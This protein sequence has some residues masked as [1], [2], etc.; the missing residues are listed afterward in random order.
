MRGHMRE[1]YVSRMAPAKS[2]RRTRRIAAGLIALVSAVW[3]LFADHPVVAS[4]ATPATIPAATTPAATTTA[5]TTTLGAAVVLPPTVAAK[6]LADVLRIAVSG[7]TSASEYNDIFAP[8]FTAHISRAQLLTVFAAALGPTT[9]LDR[10]LLSTPAGIAVVANGAGGRVKIELT[11][12]SASSKIDSLLLSPFSDAPPS[13]EPSSW[14][15]IDT[16]LRNVAPVARFVAARINTNGTCVPAHGLQPDTV[17]PLGSAFKLYV[18][19][20]VADAGSRN[21]LEWNSTIAVREDWKSLPSGDLQDQPAGKRFNVAVLADKMISISDN[22]AADHLL[23]TV[24]RAQVEATMTTAGMAQPSK[25]RPFLTTR[26]LFLLKASQYPKNAKRYLALDEAGRRALLD[27]ALASASLSAAKV[28]STPRDVDTLEWF[29]TP[30][31]I[32]RAFAYLGRIEAR[33]S[34][35]AI[36]HA[37]TINDG[38]LKLDSNSWPTVWFKGGSEPGVLTLAYLAKNVKGERF[39]VVTM[40]SNPSKALNEQDAAMELLAI[41]KGAFTLLTR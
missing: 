36:D 10:I 2:P 29:A 30:M 33:S 20:A 40:L 34:A 38:G 23:R 32:C 39:V 11:V 14:N 24:G 22:T 12:R 27:G 9:K 26:E 41:V 18:L 13:P 31:D 15:E 1:E 16:R 7:R 6:R 25:N 21:G 8:S 4:G 37:L 17:G 5:A 3:M 19:A 35:Q 28:W